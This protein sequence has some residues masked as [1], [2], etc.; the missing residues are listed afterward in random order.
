MAAA[1]AAV[2]VSLTPALNC[3]C[4]NHAKLGFGKEG[5]RHVVVVGSKQYLIT[6]CPFSK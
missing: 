1:A 3:D 6:V 4:G 5:R 2:I